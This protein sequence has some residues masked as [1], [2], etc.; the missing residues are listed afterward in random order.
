M[1]RKAFQ[2][3]P[4]LHK[5]V[6]AQD[7][8]WVKDLLQRGKNPNVRNRWRET[9]LHTAL[10]SESPRTLVAAL[11][12]GGADVEWSDCSNGSPLWLAAK[13][14]KISSV[15]ALAQYGADVNRQIKSGEGPLHKRKGLGIVPRAGQAPMHM[16]ASISARGV[17][18][19]LHE[20]GADVNLRDAVG[21]TPLHVSALSGK[22]RKRAFDLLVK[23]GADAAL[24][25]NEGN[26]P[27]D[28][29]NAHL[30]KM[31]SKSAV[32]RASRNSASTGK[33]PAPAQDTV[34]LQRSRNTCSRIVNPEE[35]ALVETCRRGNRGGVL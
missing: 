22:D 18:I 33:T 32:K 16:A 4:E 6:K 25:D 11:I 23:F 34:A 14:G 7:L 17:I 31:A 30:E 24:E 29:L 3:M 9:S 5:A 35:R 21:R 13:L 28:Y 1:K 12:K 10:W 8:A 27:L 2:N 19:A 15:R 20:H 26:T